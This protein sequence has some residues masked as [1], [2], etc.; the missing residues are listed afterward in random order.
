MTTTYIPT[1]EEI[2]EL[3]N[4]ISRLE[5]EQNNLLSRLEV[6][7]ETRSEI[8]KKLAE[9]Y[10]RLNELKEI[11]NIFEE[12]PTKEKE[13]NKRIT[14]KALKLGIPATILSWFI[15]GAIFNCTAGAIIGVVLATGIT[16]LSSIISSNKQ[17]KK[18]KKIIKNNN[19]LKIKRKIDSEENNIDKYLAEQR[20]I[21]QNNNI[22]NRVFC[23][24]KTQLESA[25]L[26]LSIIE[27]SPAPSATKTKPHQKT[28]Q[29]QS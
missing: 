9:C 3:K 6:N 11:K 24:N 2:Q 4:E 25:K 26:K 16:V 19:L 14:K 27:P 18:D 29:T 20:Q 8:D 23:E 1:A 28:K 15:G 21:D 17:L 7:N 12:F 10:K 22:I 13:V 5:Y